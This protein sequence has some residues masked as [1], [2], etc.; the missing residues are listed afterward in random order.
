MI[1]RRFQMIGKNC[2]IGVLNSGLKGYKVA[3]TK[4]EGLIGVPAYRFT[5]RRHAGRLVIGILV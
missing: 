5:Y 2:S 3:K 1:A 4:K